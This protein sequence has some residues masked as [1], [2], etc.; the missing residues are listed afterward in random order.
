MS[1][2]RNLGIALVSVV[3]ACGGDGTEPPPTPAS[4]VAVGA[5][6]V[7][8][9]VV[10]T[11]VAAAPTFEVRS[12]GGA[13]LANVPVSVAVTSGGGALVG[14]PTVSLAGP[15]SIGVWTLGNTSGAQTVTVT[16]AGITP[17]T[18]TATALPGAATN[19]VMVEGNNQ[20]GQPSAPLTSPIRVRVRDAFNNPVPDV[21]VNWVVDAGGGSVAAASSASNTQGIATAPAWT[22][23]PVGT[24]AAQT[25]SASLG[26]STVQFSALPT[27]FSITLRYAGTPPNATIQTAFTNAVNR[28]RTIIV[29]DLEDVPVSNL[30]I[31]EGCVSP[32][33][34]PLTEVIDDIVI[35]AA[36]V[37]IDG[38]GSVLGRAGPCA[39]RN[40]SSNLPWFGSMMFDIADLDDMAASGR[41][42]RVILHEMLHVIGVGTVWDT[43]GL[44]ADATQLTARFLGTLARTACVTDLGGAVP[45]N[46]AVPV[47]NCADLAPGTVCQD[48]T[49]DSHWKE[50]IFQTELMTGYA[51]FGVH[52]LSSMT[53]QSLADLGYTVNLGA[54]EPFT[55]PPP[56][57]QS[58][59]R[60]AG[61][62]GLRL[63]APLLPMFTLDAAGRAVLLPRP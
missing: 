21:A 55:L 47:E 37:A 4:V 3:A 17:L 26:A 38:P 23:G 15:T 57:I 43:Q 44:L 41:L 8:G 11:A 51:G 36:V 5:N 50:S 24:G 9:S 45:C 25:M 54:A 62:P 14:A 28:I 30:V 20:A 39:V 7:T 31:P 22:L 40:W 48:G 34:A 35:Y 12:A 16:V 33:Q 1:L 52:P 49:R 46:T 56:A 42:E 2:R 18:L 32:Q 60:A 6:P 19:I 29:A 10:G 61:P 53:I 58:A 59:L 27:A 63:P 13:A